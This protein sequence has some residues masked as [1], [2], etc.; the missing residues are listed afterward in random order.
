[1]RAG[2]KGLDELL[3]KEV[4]RTDEEL[5]KSMTGPY[6]REILMGQHALSHAACRR[7]TTIL[8]GH[9]YFR[10]LRPPRF[11]FQIVISSCVTRGISD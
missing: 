2:V 10:H 6:T 4:A 5:Q 8:T 1:M 9:Y 7:A 3:P 11:C